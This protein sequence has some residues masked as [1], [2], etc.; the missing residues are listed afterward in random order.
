MEEIKF[1]FT[2]KNGNFIA[3]RIATLDELLDDSFPIEKMEEDINCDSCIGDIEDYPEYK[4]FK[5][6][7]TGLEDFYEGDYFRQKGF[8]DTYLIEWK[9]GM[10]CY[11]ILGTYAPLK[12]IVD[13][14]NEIEYV[15]NIH[16]EVK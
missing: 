13:F 15:G 6:Q 9:E 4:V 8:K 16:E 5:D 2:F 14:I 7:Y 10:F 3:T 1:R 12:N 11:K